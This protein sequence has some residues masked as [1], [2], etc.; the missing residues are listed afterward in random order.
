VDYGL[1]TGSQGS[2]PLYGSNIVVN[3]YIQSNTK[4]QPTVFPDKSNYN[5]AP[6]NTL[7]GQ[8]FNPSLTKKYESTNGNV[9]NQGTI[10]EQFPVGS[11]FNQNPSRNNFQ[12]YMNPDLETT[13]FLN[14]ESNFEGSQFLLDQ[15]NQKL[16][17][18]TNNYGAPNSYGNIPK[19]KNT[20]SNEQKQINQPNKIRFPFAK[21]NP[22]IS[23]ISLNE[24][25][26][27]NQRPVSDPSNINSWIKSQLRDK[28]RT[29][30]SINANG[31]INEQSEHQNN[32]FNKPQSTFE[33]GNREQINNNKLTYT[34]NSYDSLGDTS[35]SHSDN[36]QQLPVSNGQGYNLNPSSNYPITSK[37]DQLE[38]PQSLYLSSQNSQ[39]NNDPKIN[40]QFRIVVPDIQKPIKSSKQFA[41]SSSQ[42]TNSAQESIMFIPDKKVLNNY[43]GIHDLNRNEN[44]D[45][46]QS[47]SYT[48][49]SQSHSQQF[50]VYSSSASSSN[51]PNGFNG[52]KPHPTE[53]SKFL[54]CANGRTFEM[55]CGPGTLFNP[56]ISVC[57][58]PYNVECKRN[59]VKPD[60]TEEYYTTQATVEE[61]TEDYNPLIDQRQKFDHDTS[62]SELVTESEPL[63]NQNEAVLETLPTE[64]RQFKILRNPTSIDLP[65]NFL[66]NSSITPISPNVMNNKF[67][68][69]AVRIDL[70]PNN[71]QS[72]RLRGSPK[73]FEGFL[74]VQ[75][76]PFQWG[77]VCDEPNSWTIDKANIVCKQ[78]GFKR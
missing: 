6:Q 19:T 53:C 67:D 21:E 69:V 59:Y 35:Q 54:S 73:N 62:G 65:D 39:I 10:Q 12:E 28:Q 20:F 58:Y 7:N 16:T 8:V 32:H 3:G 40:K 38:Q 30:Q 36:E 76:K 68:N 64:N 4:E 25:S 56:I 29:V 50:P 33:L 55:D 42:N 70:K 71:T 51:C 13:A 48:D 37:S 1:Q 45:Q 44:T 63:E 17:P 77:V 2:K 11:N 60:I 74:Q 78:L 47:P 14:R 75:E 27:Q 41:L 72:I 46:I 24:Y 26:N 49:T 5:F 18:N 31:Y 23:Q 43:N 22:P 34:Q 52:I 9:H 61:Y 66:L 15:Y 57:D